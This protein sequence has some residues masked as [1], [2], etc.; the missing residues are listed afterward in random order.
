MKPLSSSVLALAPSM[1]VA[2]DTKAKELKAA[3]Q[4]I[5]ALGAGEPDFDTPEHIKNAAIASLREGKT[6]YTAPTGIPELKKAVADKLLRENGVK[7]PAEQVV[8]TSGVKHAVSN[9][10]QTIINPGDEIVIPLKNGE[11]GFIAL[12]YRDV[13]RAHSPVQGGERLRH[14][15]IVEQCF[16]ECCGHLSLCGCT[17][18]RRW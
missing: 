13:A 5:V 7:I 6:K 4:D 10:L 18:Q 8:I 11:G 2:I 12:I 3:G 9:V 16:G 15:E 14:A 17:S 1:T